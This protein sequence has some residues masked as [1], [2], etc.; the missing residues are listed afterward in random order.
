MYSWKFGML[1]EKEISVPNAFIISVGSLEL[2]ELVL[3]KLYAKN[4]D[5]GILSSIHTV[6]PSSH[7]R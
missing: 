4:A 7:R 1:L 5:L 2:S 3:E 6:S